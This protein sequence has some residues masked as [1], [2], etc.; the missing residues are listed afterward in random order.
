MKWLLIV[1]LGGSDVA[2]FKDGGIATA[3]VTERQCRAALTVTDEWRAWC[4][5]PDG[6]RVPQPRRDARK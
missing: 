1:C 6:Q 2:C 4:I 3:M 5:G